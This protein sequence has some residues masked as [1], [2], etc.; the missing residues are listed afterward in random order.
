[1]N[2]KL[3]TEISK[4]G[5]GVF[6]VSV[7]IFLL[8]LIPISYTV[9]YSNGL[10]GAA[11]IEAD[12]TDPTKEPKG[13]SQINYYMTILSGVIG[14]IGLAASAVANAQKAKFERR[15]E[16]AKYK[17]AQIQYEMQIREVEILRMELEAE[18]LKKRK[19]K[20]KL[21]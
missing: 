10:S 7:V 6:F 17:T 9:G 3:L 15:A 21:D 1:M 18:K 19:N 14:S 12:P 11:G 8:S 13:L 5:R 20:S 2:P 4:A 16:E